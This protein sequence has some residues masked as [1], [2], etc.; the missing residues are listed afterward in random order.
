MT[1]PIARLLIVDDELPSMR[2]LCDTLQDQGYETAGF[3]SGEAALE[4]MQ[5]QRF[6]LLLTDLMMPK[7][8]GFVVIE[9]I[10]QAKDSLIPVVMLTANDNEYQKAFAEVLG[11]DAFLHKP[12]GAKELLAQINKLCPVRDSQAIDCDHKTP[13]T[14]F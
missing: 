5:D 13:D 2:A 11:V 14:A 12:I 1:P 10:K 8:S 3:T 7:M 4:A 9:R 6:D